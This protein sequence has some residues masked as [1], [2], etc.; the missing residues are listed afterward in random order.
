MHP[1]FNLKTYQFDGM[2]VRPAIRDL[3]LLHVDYLR[4]HPETKVLPIDAAKRN[5]NLYDLYRYLS[6]INYPTELHWI[7]LLVND[8]S[9]HIELDQSVQELMFPSAAVVQTIISTS[10]IQ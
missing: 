3:M 9:S 5:L 7:I 6:D 4:N 1:M 10:G 2:S 8:L